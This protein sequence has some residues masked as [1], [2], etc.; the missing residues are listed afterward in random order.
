MQRYPDADLANLDIDQRLFMIER[1][2]AEELFLRIRLDLH[3]A[4]V[5]NAGDAVTTLTRL[6]QL[7]S[8]VQQAIAAEFRALGPVLTTAAQVNAVVTQ[9]IR[10][11]LTV[12]EEF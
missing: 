2:T 10:T 4:I 1:Y 5:K 7:H 9:V 3:A 11:T 6:K 8:Y 12:F